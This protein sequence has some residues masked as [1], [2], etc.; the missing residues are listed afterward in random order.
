MEA[1][2]SGVPQNGGAVTVLPAGGRRDVAVDVGAGLTLSNL[3]LGPRACV[4][5]DWAPGPRVSGWGSLGCGAKKNVGQLSARFARCKI[6][7]QLKFD[8]N[9]LVYFG[10]F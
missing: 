2:C 3:L 8:R 7:I 5:V 10:A 9:L 1:P 6:F 4:A